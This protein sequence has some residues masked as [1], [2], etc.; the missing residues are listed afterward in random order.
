MYSENF[1]SKQEKSEAIVDWFNNNESPTYTDF[2][3]LEGS[4]LV[5]Y[6]YAKKLHDKGELSVNN[7]NKFVL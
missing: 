6:D 1:A 4:N 2:K 3:K 5:E 7:L